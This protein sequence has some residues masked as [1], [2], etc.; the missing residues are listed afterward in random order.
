MTLVSRQVGR[1]ATCAGERTARDI[2]CPGILKTTWNFDLIRLS[3]GLLGTQYP[4]L[5]V[6]LYKFYLLLLAMVLQIS[7]MRYVSLATCFG[8]DDVTPNERG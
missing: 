8:S 6:Q 4:Y 1:L 7:R 3:P 5:V 2:L